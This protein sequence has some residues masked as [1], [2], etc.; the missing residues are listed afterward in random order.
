MTNLVGFLAKQVADNEVAW[1]LGT[2]GA[3]A[4]FTRDANEPV[5]LD[6]TDGSVSAVTVR[7]G[8]RITP[9]PELRPIAS[10]SPTTESWS[11][12]VALCLPET[13]CAM[14]GHTEFTEVGLDRGALR[15][16]DRAGVLFDLGLG[17]LHADFHVRSSD[18][19]VI[20]ALRATT[21]QSVFSPSSGTMKVI[22]AANPHRV[23]VSRLGRIEV[24]QPIPPAGG[25]SPTGPHTHVL[26]KLLAH[27]RTHSA[28]EPLPPGWIPCAHFYPPHPARDP[29]GQHQPFAAERHVAFQVLLKRYGDPQRLALKERVIDS[30]MSGGEPAAIV[31]GDDR[32][33]RATVRV[34]LRQ[35]RASNPS[36]AALAAWLSAHDRFDPGEPQDAAEAA[37]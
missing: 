20:A 22:L 32:F 4:E 14:G 31:I 17:A 28:N 8:L 13:S 3:L 7:G 6:Q 23:F 29:F 27:R 2:F 1:S 5:V 35:L 19:D 34:A 16:E 30:V 9:H 25:K 24:Y 11:H 37:H 10:E 26:P 12:R 33:A 15:E 18:P 36:P 21:G